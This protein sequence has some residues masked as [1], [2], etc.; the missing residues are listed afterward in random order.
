MEVETVQS[1][2][3]NIYQSNIYREELGWLHLNNEARSQVNVLQSYIPVLVAYPNIQ[4]TTSSTNPVMKTV[5]Y[6][7]SYSRFIVA[8]NNLTR[9]KLHEQNK[10]PIFLEAALAL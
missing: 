1:V 10:A 8:P 9:K 4:V 3:M 5:L 2:H 6:A 7:R